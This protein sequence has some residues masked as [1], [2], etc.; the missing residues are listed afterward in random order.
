MLLSL[1]RL[2]LVSY[3]KTQADSLHSAHIPFSQALQSMKKCLRIIADPPLLLHSIQPTIHA[4]SL[5]SV[6]PLLFC[7]KAATSLQLRAVF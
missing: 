6:N 4:A 5:K 3:G 2:G 7:N 1:V